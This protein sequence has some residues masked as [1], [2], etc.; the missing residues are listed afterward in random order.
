MPAKNYSKKI[1]TPDKCCTARGS[2]LRVHY[3]NTRETAA[4]IKGMGLRR[5]VQFLENVL[6]QKEAVPFRRH[7]GGAGRHA[8][9]KHHKYPNVG[10]PKKSAEF[11][12]SLLLNAES[13]AEFK[14]LDVDAMKIT[15]IQVQR[16]T[17]QRRRTYRAH[18][19]IGAYL[20]S[21][22]HIELILTQQDEPVSRGSGAKSSV[23]SRRPKKVSKKKLARERLRGQQQAQ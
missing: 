3:K 9:A 1:E 7:T 2:D 21:P 22:C 17:K 20:C 14:Q 13:N 4:A 15:H 8:Q 5:A 10:W 23:S 12:L 6:E 16:A 19:R 11:L 18:G